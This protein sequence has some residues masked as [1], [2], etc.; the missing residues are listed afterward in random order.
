MRLIYDLPDING[1]RIGDYVIVDILN[2]PDQSSIKCA[3][4]NFLLKL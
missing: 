1:A 2:E 3:I 4:Q